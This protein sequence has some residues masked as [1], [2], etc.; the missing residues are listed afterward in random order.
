[1]LGLD[2]GT[3]AKTAGSGSRMPMAQYPPSGAG[4][5]TASGPD[6]SRRRSGPGQELGVELRGV[7]AHQKRRSAGGDQR[8]AE[9]VPKTASAL[10]HRLEPRG[11]GALQL[12][13]ERQEATAGGR[14][15]HR[16]QRVRRAP[17]RRA[18]AASPGVQGGHRRVF[19]RPATGALAIT[20]SATP[21]IA[22]PPPCP[23]TARA[24]PRSEPL[25]FER[26]AARAR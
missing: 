8:M 11:Q 26:P 17:R 16:G 24:L 5:I 18:A 21:L 1:M 6:P 4:P 3:P 23:A 7:H 19:E 2:I 15:A 13:V 10:G 12:A 25:T 22:G 20:T 9:A 14:G